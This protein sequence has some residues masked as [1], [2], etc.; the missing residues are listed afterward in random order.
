MSIL[1]LIVLSVY[2]HI[3]AIV[4]DR[5]GDR[6]GWAVYTSLLWATFIIY[7]AARVV[8][9]AVGPCVQIGMPV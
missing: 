7:L 5:S 4:R 8:S 1:V 6:V 2:F 3:F 9:S